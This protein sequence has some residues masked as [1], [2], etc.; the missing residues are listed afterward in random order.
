MIELLL[1]IVFA[2]VLG[3]GI[4]TVVRNGVTSR[5]FHYRL[6]VPA[7]EPR[8]MVLGSPIQL[9]IEAPKP[10]PEDIRRELDRTPAEEWDNEFH[11]ML[12][13]S[14]SSKVLAIRASYAY[15]GG[16]PTEHTVLGDC[17]CTECNS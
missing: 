2:G 8:R 3:G 16:E 5:R 13:G 17:T 7:P 4:M 10:I 1:G 14:S 6:E 11:R 12:E 15:E 9:A